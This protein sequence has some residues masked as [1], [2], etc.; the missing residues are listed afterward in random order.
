L[1]VR[2]AEELE[3]LVTFLDE[4]KEKFSNEVLT[5]IDYFVTDKSGKLTCNT[6]A[7]VEVVFRY[8]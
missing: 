7:D 6:I 3:E 4:R 1:I 8:I 5:L 2:S